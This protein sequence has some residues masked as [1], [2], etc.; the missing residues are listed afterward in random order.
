MSKNNTA[1]GA[2]TLFRIAVIVLIHNTPT[3]PQSNAS[4]S[5][6]GCCLTQG[7]I[8]TLLLLFMFS[9]WSQELDFILRVLPTQDILL[10][11][12][13]PM[14]VNASLSPWYRGPALRSVAP[15]HSYDLASVRLRTHREELNLST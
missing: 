15:T 14:Q 7:D 5:A 12:K 2:I 1:F 6:I 11:S 9:A 3:W 8:Y 4:Q 13:C 10:N